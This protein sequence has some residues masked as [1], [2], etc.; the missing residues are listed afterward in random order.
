MRRRV[1]PLLR[2]PIES[3]N[4][5]STDVELM[6]MLLISATFLLP[7]ATFS[8]WRFQ[9]TL[10]LEILEWLSKRSLA[11][12]I[13]ELCLTLIPGFSSYTCHCT[14]EVGCYA[15]VMWSWVGTIVDL[16]RSW[17]T[18]IL[19]VYVC[20]LPLLPVFLPTSR[21]LNIRYGYIAYLV[22]SS[23]TLWHDDLGVHAHM[24]PDPLHGGNIGRLKVHPRNCFSYFIRLSSNFSGW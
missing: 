9:N 16:L 1:G 8:P 6:R 11:Q 20:F 18:N 22:C 10:E 7:L 19:M 17:A 3:C 14:Y 21:C 15:G 12:K 24:G 23:W 13:E 5:F 4:Q 2:F